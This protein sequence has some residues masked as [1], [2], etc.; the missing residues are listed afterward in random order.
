MPR[1]TSAATA[2]QAYRCL[3]EAERLLDQPR[4]QRERLIWLSNLSPDRR[5]DVL[6]LKRK[7]YGISDAS[8]YPLLDNYVRACKQDE[9][10]CITY[11]YLCLLAAIRMAREENGL[12]IRV[13]PRP[14]RG[15]KP[16]ELRQKIALRLPE[17]NQL[18]ADG[19]SWPRVAM[20]LRRKWR[21]AFADG[22]DPSYLRK[23]VKRLNAAQADVN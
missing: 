21:R 18:R 11:D 19:Y 3:L 22:I 5:A 2:A 7:L 16:L 14:K 8:V 4:Q 13:T 23:T 12:G 17:I 15:P 6:R 1:I 10:A 9:D 20:V